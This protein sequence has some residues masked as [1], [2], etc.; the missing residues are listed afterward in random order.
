MIKETDK[1]VSYNIKL[2]K[3]LR[4]FFEEI[5]VKEQRNLSFIIRRILIKEQA[6]I[7]EQRNK[8]TK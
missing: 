7:L 2:P 1:I 5:A 8:E 6:E 4:L 3:S